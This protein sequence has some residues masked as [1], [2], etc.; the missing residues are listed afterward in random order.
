MS[1]LA[2]REGS[3][4]GGNA[5]TALEWA[6]GL[7]YRWVQID[8]AMTG[9]R[10]RELDQSARREVLTMLRKRGAGVCG[11]DL[12]VPQAHFLDAAHMDRAVGAVREALSL[13]GE[14]GQAGQR[15]CVCVALPDGV[16]PAL[17]HELVAHAEWVG[18]EVAD[19]SWPGSIVERV[20]RAI[21]PAAV[22]AGGGDVVKAVAGLKPQPAVA[23]LSDLDAS[24][25][26]EAG[27]G[28]LDAASYRVALSVAGY[29]RPLVVDVRS[30]RDQAGAARRLLDKAEGPLA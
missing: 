16:V 18:A 9:L 22:L 29:A 17:V 1:G 21:D 8:A 2:L 28:R 30:L 5:R 14:W 26:V 3:A 4:W 11:L 24:G 27:S 7:G 20:G 6:C 25:R 12:F 23:R 19:C 10:P 15:L 13:A